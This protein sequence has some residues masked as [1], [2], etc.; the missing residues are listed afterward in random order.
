[1]D[2]SEYQLALA[3]PARRLSLVKRWKWRRELREAGERMSVRLTFCVCTR[4]NVRLGSFVASMRLVLTR[5][6][7]N[8]SP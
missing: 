3:F 7:P 6:L 5:R 8:F 4:T 2:T 1:M